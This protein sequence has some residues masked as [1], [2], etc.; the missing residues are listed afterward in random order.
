MC[1]VDPWKVAQSKKL[2]RETMIALAKEHCP[3]CAS[4]NVDVSFRARTG[5][6]LEY[7]TKCPN[8]GRERVY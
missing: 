5:V 8:C 1:L 7:Y 4:G 3:D 6:G 2:V